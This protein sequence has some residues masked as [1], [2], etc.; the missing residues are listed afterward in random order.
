[1]SFEDT[2]VRLWKRLPPEDR[3]LAATAFWQEPAPEVLGAALAVLVKARHLRPQ[4][5]RALPAA[6]Q[7]RILASVLDLGETLAAS[8]LVALHLGPRRSM[9]SA[10]LDALGLPHDDGILKDE[11]QPV[12]LTEPAARAAVKALAA[13]YPPGQVGVYLNTLWLQDPVRWEALGRS[14]DWL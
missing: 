10:F 5:A 9:L 7:A 13:S 14:A 3:L 6:S 1:M 11:G 12:P 8:L 4:A 2:A